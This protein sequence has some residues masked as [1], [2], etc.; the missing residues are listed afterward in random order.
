MG[1]GDQWTGMAP[2]L[3]VSN[4]RQVKRHLERTSKAKLLIK[5]KLVQPRYIVVCGFSGSSRGNCTQPH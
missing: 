3:L 2:L 5:E 1:S 4:L